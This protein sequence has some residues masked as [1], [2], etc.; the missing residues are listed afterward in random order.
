MSPPFTRKSA[1]K[2]STGDAA[3]LSRL[4]GRKRTRA[5]GRERQSAS[6][7]LLPL[8]TIALP[9]PPALLTPDAIFS[10]SVGEQPV[11]LEIGFGG[12][13]HLAA[14]MRRHTDHFFIGAE[15]F[16]NGMASFLKDIRNDPH[17]RIRVWPEDALVL[18]GRLVPACLDGIY[19]LNPDPW[20]KKRHS[21]RRII[22]P[23]NLEIFARILKPGGHLIM[24]TDVD[25]LAAWM[26]TQAMN[27]R[28]FEW[29]AEKAEDWRHAPPDWIATRYEEKGRAKGRVQTYL[30]F[31]K[32]A[33]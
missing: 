1:E 10:S 13:E 12:G 23:E 27:C 5:L 16:I 14:L 29:A 19:I 20:P 28:N 17:N 11:W 24:S 26:V 15:P 31:R 7:E 25:N 8:L 33:D 21:K 3:P 32:R 9:D 4:Y 18:A 22:R 30:I 6:D 2:P